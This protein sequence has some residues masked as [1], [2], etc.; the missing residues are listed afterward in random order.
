MTIVTGSSCS[1]AIDVDVLT[2][3]Y[4]STISQTTSTRY[5]L[6]NFAYSGG[7]LTVTFTGTG[8]T[9]TDGAPSGGT[10]TGVTEQY[11]GGRIRMDWSGFSVPMATFWNDMVAAE[12]TG[13][14]TAVNNLFFGGNDTFTVDSGDHSIASQVSFFGYSGNDV[15]NLGGRLDNT[16]R[17][18]GGAGTDT[19]SLNG[20]YSD[21][22]APFPFLIEPGELNSIE[23]ITMAGAYSYNIAT[24]AGA[25]AS[26]ATMTIDASAVTAGH[27]LTF[28]G[29]TET[30]TKFV[31]TGG[32]GNDSL[33]SSGSADTL[34]GGGGNDT[35]DGGA[36]N[37]LLD[38]GS[39]SDTA[40]YEYSSAGVTVNLNIT[41][42]QAVG[43]GQGSDTLV[44][45]ENLIGSSQ[46]DRLTGNAA[47]NV[48]YGGTG[49]DTL[50]GGAGTD[51]ASYLF[52]YQS[53]F[54]GVTIDLSVSGPQTGGGWGGSDTL[55]SIENIIGSLGDDNLTGN[56]GNNVL[57]G[58]AGQDTL[59]GGA[60]DD[61]LLGGLDGA[62]IDGGPGND[63]AS[64][65]DATSGVAVNL[66]IAT[67]QNVGGTHGYDVLTSIENLTGS[68]YND[69]L[70][71]NAGNNVLT[72]GAGNDTLN[73]GLGSDTASYSGA[74]SGVT[75]NLDITTAQAVGGG[76]G[77]DT[78]A[79][80]ENLTGSSYGDT[81]TGNSGANILT[82]GA[83]ADT[84]A[85][86]AGNDTFNM[87]GN[88]TSADTIDG[89][90]GTDTLN[91]D[92]DYSAGVVLGATTLLNVETIILAAGHTYNLTTNNAT[93]AAGQTLTVDGA[94]LEATNVLT[95]NGAAETNGKFVITGGAG[96]DTLT[97]GAGA[98][99]F[100]LS[101]GGNDTAKG[102]GGNDT[103][104]FG[105]VLT[106]A[107]KID[108]GTGM[109]TLNLNGNYS[110]GVVLG[111][112]TLTNVET[113]NL[114]AGHGYK[115][116]T[117]DATVA[118][119]QALTVTASALA[120]SN[121]LIFNGSAETNGKFVITG[122]AGKDTLTG[123]KGADTI[124]GGAGAD[125]LNG[126]AGADKF[127]YKAISDSRSTTYDTITGFDATSDK[128]DM[129]FAVTGINTAVT[130]GALSSGTTF[131][132]DLGTA[133]GSHLTSHHAIAFTPNSGSLSGHHFLIVDCNGTAG[134]QAG[135][136]LVI[137]LVSPT[138]MNSLGIGTFT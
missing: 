20:D 87:A 94:V 10:L 124:T 44:S 68:A 134:Y 75:V 42:A 81:L 107:D 111:A 24:D 11:G 53:D 40:T 28:D 114:A 58:G 105:A 113:V 25:F 78:L 83:G 16:D 95:F 72:G 48:L 1:N 63:T 17:L 132:S 12:G 29:W 102:L 80:V 104:K 27:S 8:F 86:G 121:S 91:L 37:D 106:A 43:G 13:D 116:T 120:S 103:F 109:D 54:L 55:I 89:G 112:T 133:I 118:S 131:N 82:G 46:N 9:Y 74:T 33:R 115:L 129:W 61:T 137:E 14:L 119:G 21:Y 73:G 31:I 19:L 18:D 110:V 60:G 51:T 64:Y 99:S 127:V 36:G 56:S 76:Q 96:N 128:I 15:F 98:D 93:V 62:T 117:N 3:L 70:I 84:L 85:G 49:N 101:M 90:T 136:D 52:L 71:G 41:D 35:L 57:D 4:Y 138:H 130:S 92:G 34:R 6:T 69:E 26:M 79:S 50:D 39:G 100:D 30:T 38:G 122:G 108:G 77:S 59:N 32:A 23:K 135:A 7:Y 47:N 125:K 97:G 88:L 123:G 2:S 67:Q 45:I 66:N 22:Y 65:A 5:V 126:G